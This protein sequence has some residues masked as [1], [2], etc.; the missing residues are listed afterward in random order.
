MFY[1]C[2]V[3]V[4]ICPSYLLGEQSHLIDSGRNFLVQWTKRAILFFCSNLRPG[5]KNIMKVWSH[6]LFLQRI[7]GFLRTIKKENVKV[8]LHEG[9]KN[10]IPIVIVSHSI[11]Q[12]AWARN[13]LKQTGDSNK[14]WLKVQIELLNTDWGTSPWLK[15]YFWHFYFSA[16]PSLS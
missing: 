3:Y 9:K 13:K 10:G 11:L 7:R 15:I 12:V 14:W 8:T 1:S 2:H 4:W 5:E 6:S 16:L